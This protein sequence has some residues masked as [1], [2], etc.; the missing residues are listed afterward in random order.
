MILAKLKPQNGQE[1]R[2]GYPTPDLLVED[3][4][5]LVPKGPLLLSMHEGPIHWLSLVGVLADEL[6]EVDEAKEAFED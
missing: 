2:V 3:L 4:S 6:K 1:S 5:K